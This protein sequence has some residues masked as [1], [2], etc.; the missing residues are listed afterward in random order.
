[1]RSNR[2]AIPPPTTTR[3]VSSIA[4]AT[5][6]RDPSARVRRSRK[7]EGALDLEGKAA[8]V[9]GSSSDDGVGAECAKILAAR[10]CNVV[11]NYA[12]NRA[13]GE[14]VAA[15]CAAAGVQSVAVRGDVAKDGDCR[16]LVQAAVE[17]WGRLDV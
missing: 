10:G 6:G 7:A 3:T 16:A 5:P 11:V 1:M 8:I 12:S 13:G 2:R 14:K 9:T 4:A 15:A 17:R